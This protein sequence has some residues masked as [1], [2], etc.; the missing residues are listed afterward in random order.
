MGYPVVH[1]IKRFKE[2]G[3]YYEMNDFDTAKE[4]IINI[5]Q[6]HDRNREAYIA[7]AKQLTWRFS[8]YN[9]ENAKA[10]VSLI[11]DK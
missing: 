4:Q 3:Y 5:T 7:H 2:F 9:P 8:A 6:N 11:L 1:N 10:W